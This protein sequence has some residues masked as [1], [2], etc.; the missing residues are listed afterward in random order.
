MANPQHRTA[1]DPN[2]TGWPK[3]IPY[4]I[5]NEACERFSY[6]GMKA[7]LQV[8]LTMLFAAV[9]IGQQHGLSHSESITESKRM[10]NDSSYVESLSDEE[11]AEIKELRNEAEEEGQRIAHL[12]VAAVYALP[13]LGAIVA[14]RLLGKYMTILSLSI[15]YCIGH[16]VLAIA[17]NTLGGMYLGLGLIAIGAGGIKPCVSAHVGDQFGK[18]NWGLVSAVY[19]IFYFSINFG[20]FIATLLIPWLN[21][22][23]GTAV[24]FGL[25]GIL[26]LLATIAFWMGRKVFIHVPAHPA[27]RLGLLDS[28]SSILLF[29]A[30]LGLPIFYQDFAELF[31]PEAS[32]GAIRGVFWLS[33]VASGVGG[34][35]LFRIRQKEKQDH[36]FL[37]ILLYSITSL[38]DGKNSEAKRKAITEQAPAK[39]IRRNW[40]FASAADNFGEKTAEGPMA[41]IRIILVFAMVSVFWALF[42]QHMTSWVRQAQR[43]DLYANFFVWKGELLPSQIQTLNPLFVMLLIPACQFVIYPILNMFISMTPLRKMTLGMF[44]A[45]SS[46]AFV[47]LIQKWIDAAEVAGNPNSISVG[48]QIF[49]YLLITLAEVMVSITGLEFAYTQAPKSMK[50]TIMGFWLL[51]VSFGNVLVAFLTRFSDYELEQFF[52]LFA[53]LMAGAAIIFGG[54]AMFYKYQDYSDE[55]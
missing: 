21:A 14:D 41:V 36:G 42:D 6:Y 38:F 27:G 40:L 12:F 33:V 7:I 8:H 22:T 10:L 19:Q 34:F 37:A 45:S 26:M 28:F 1:P 16:F 5:G 11:Q 25:P 31:F 53:G 55:Q 13:M 18:G 47:A 20:S 44:I 52:W 29:L 24:A 3:G 23:Y 46:F 30:F 9:M 51:A 54:Y 35:V 39:S 2:E 43:M 50:S 49:P 48:W 32:E 15:V 4:I 17:E